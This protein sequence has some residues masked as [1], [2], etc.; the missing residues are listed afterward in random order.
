MIE[1]H[2]ISATVDSDLGSL[3]DSLE[4]VL[5]ERDTASP[6][7]PAAQSWRALDQGDLIRVRL[8]LAELGYDDYGIFRVDECT[9][10]ISENQVRQRVH[11]RDKAALLIDEG[12]PA[13]TQVFYLGAYPDDDP[14]EETNPSARTLLKWL[15]QRVGLSLVWDAMPDGSYATDYQLK[16][17]TISPED[18]LSSQ[19][20]RILDPLRVSRR[21]Y[22]DAWVD[23]ENLVVRRRGNGANTGSID[24][25][26]GMVTSIQRT[27]QPAVGKIEVTGDHHTAPVTPPLE[28]T[29][30]TETYGLDWLTNQWE[31]LLC[32]ETARR[33]YDLIVSAEKTLGRLLIDETITVEQD[34]NDPDRATTRV[35]KAQYRYDGLHRTIERREQVTVYQDGGWVLESESLV[36]FAQVTPTD[37][38]TTTFEWALSDDGEGGQDYRLKAGFP[39][40]V[41]APGTLQSGLQVQPQDEAQQYGAT[42]NGGGSLKRTYSNDQLQS[43]YI[44]SLIADDLAVESGKWL[45]TVSLQWPRPF[46]YRKGQKVTLTGLPG[47]CPDLVD[48]VIT[49]LHTSFDEE[50][51]SWVHEVTLEAWREA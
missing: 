30:V 5:V 28:E 44:C 50:A 10:D 39:R 3:A 21:Y 1:V 22:C 9:V 18:S 41:T 25:S 12:R 38:Q 11:A 13:D 6:L 37:V 47:G 15:A 48:A 14:E 23:G 42:A 27:R 32:R 26:Q 2:P 29:E 17:F 31:I 34:L 7:T 4:L 16:S 24:C 49:R 40:R 35:Q 46:P 33:R 36:R 45:Y 20:S 51:A 19:I 8:G 43:D